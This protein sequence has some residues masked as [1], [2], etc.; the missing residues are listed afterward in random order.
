MR[1]NDNVSAGAREQ[2]CT[3]ADCLSVSSRARK[4]EGRTDMDGRSAEEVKRR[5][6]EDKLC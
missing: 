3:C 5:R 2:R 6:T 4:R 1:M